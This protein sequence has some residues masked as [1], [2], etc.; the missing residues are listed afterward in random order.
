[1][2]R[3]SIIEKTLELIKYEKIF[4]NTLRHKGKGQL[5]NREGTNSMATRPANESRA[6]I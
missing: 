3:Y 1:M 6:I 2:K 4:R 5:R